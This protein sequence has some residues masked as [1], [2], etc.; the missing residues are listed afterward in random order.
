MTVEDVMVELENSDNESDYDSSGSE[1]DFEGYIGETIDH[2]QGDD[3]EDNE[4]SEEELDGIIPSIPS[5]IGQ[6][7]ISVPIGGDRP[8]YILLFVDSNML[9][10]IVDQTNLCAEQYLASHSLAPRSRIRQWMKQDH[11]L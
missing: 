9:Q 11:T 1:D 7:G 6:A 4:Q 5:Y 2:T 10:H 8:L 3:C